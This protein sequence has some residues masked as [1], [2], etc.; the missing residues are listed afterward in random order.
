MAVF[1]SVEA[2]IHAAIEMQQR[3]ND[4]PP[5]S[6][7]QMAIRVGISQ[8]EQTHPG[9]ALPEEAAREAALLAGA[10]RSGQILV[11]A[12]MR[13]S[14]PATLSPLINEVGSAAIAEF[15]ISEPVLEITIPEAEPLTANA[16]ESEQLKPI[17]P[18]SP[19][20]CL[21]LRYDGDVV[22]LNERKTTIR[23]GR[24]TTSDLVIR[25][26]RASRNHAMIERRGSQV[27]LID[28]STN[29]T[30]VVIEGMPEHFLKHSECTLR[31]KGLIS[32]AS[33][34][35]TPDA[36]CAEFEFV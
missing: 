11:S 18:G 8:G 15:G 31:G 19:G 25:D 36:D 3:V 9:Q 33:S 34:S 12:G 13:A 7:V 2:S 24:D 10:A 22:L 1:D 5:V 30:Y 14:I 29:G 27:F 4:L 23:M 21:R 6:G 35:T 32:F 26:R 16:I 17:A 28:K 20:G